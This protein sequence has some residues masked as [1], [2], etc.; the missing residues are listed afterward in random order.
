MA[1]CIER[2]RE[3]ER[4]EGGGGGGL[5]KSLIC[6]FYLKI[7]KDE[8]TNVGPFFSIKNLAQRS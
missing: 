6:F 3:R 4:E 8:A 5:S 1:L 7:E 2:E